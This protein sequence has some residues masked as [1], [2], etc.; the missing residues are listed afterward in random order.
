MH[1]L[2]NE[3][4]EM[5]QGYVPQ[6]WVMEL[7]KNYVIWRN[8]HLSDFI[9]AGLSDGNLRRVAWLRETFIPKREIFTIAC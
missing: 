9:A 2:E 8:R 1:T 3:F 7:L 4:I 6:H 5:I